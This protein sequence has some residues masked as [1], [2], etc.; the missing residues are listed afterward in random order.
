MDYPESIY[1]RLKD[2]QRCQVNCTLIAPIMEASWSVPKALAVFE[3]ISNNNTM[4]F[5][6]IAV[7]LQRTLQV[8]RLKGQQLVGVRPLH[9]PSA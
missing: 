4:D 3:L 2:A 7:A 5:T 9:N 1:V 6:F 8:S